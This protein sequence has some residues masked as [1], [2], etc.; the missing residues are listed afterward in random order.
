M[1][2][3]LFISLR[4]FFNY[5][6]EQEL[7]CLYQRVNSVE[8]DTQILNLIKCKK[9]KIYMVTQLTKIIIRKN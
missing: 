4:D 3:T 2:Q 1:G 9:K 5:Q 7:K 8:E 6:D